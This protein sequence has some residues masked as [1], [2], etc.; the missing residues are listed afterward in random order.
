MIRQL[1]I[2]ATIGLVVLTPIVARAQGYGGG[3]GG[4][5]NSPAD[6]GFDEMFRYQMMMEMQQQLRLQQ[7]KAL[8]CKART[9]PDLVDLLESRHRGRRSQEEEPAR[10]PDRHEGEVQ[11]GEH[12][13]GHDEDGHDEDGHDP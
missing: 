9:G 8:R 10:H 2:L 5:G 13:G 12:E 1:A 4:Y 3:G 11:D 7:K 6:S